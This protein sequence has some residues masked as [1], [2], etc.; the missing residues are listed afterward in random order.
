MKA[1]PKTAV[2]NSCY[3]KHKEEVLTIEALNNW[4]LKGVISRGPH[5][6]KYKQ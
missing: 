2:T 3:Q 6:N 1:F 4:I 5:K